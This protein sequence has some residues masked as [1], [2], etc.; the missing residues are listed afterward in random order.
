MAKRKVKTM[1]MKLV[2]TAQT[3]CVQAAPRCERQWFAAGSELYFRSQVFL[4]DQEEPHLHP[5]Q[6]CIQKGECL[7]PTACSKPGC[8]AWKC[9]VLRPPPP[10]QYD[11]VVRQHVLFVEQKI[12]RTKK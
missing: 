8:T 3:G 5:T 11:P 9:T 6:A 4:H 1:M 10:S 2:S 12:S 7:A